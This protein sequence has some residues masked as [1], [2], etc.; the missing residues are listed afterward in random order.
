MFS[1]FALLAF[2]GLI[3]FVLAFSGT[4]V[5]ALGIELTARVAGL[6]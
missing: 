6:N 5:V 4:A 2:E 3:A 1:K